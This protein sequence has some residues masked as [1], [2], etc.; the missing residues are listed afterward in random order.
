[1]KEREEKRR[2]GN[3]GMGGKRS[4]KRGRGSIQ[5]LL[6]FALQALVFKLYDVLSLKDAQ[7]WGKPSLKKTGISQN[8]RAT[9]FWA[10]WKGVG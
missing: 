4:E 7:L 3:E 1:M 2:E 6:F 9:T 8:R 10:L 5:A